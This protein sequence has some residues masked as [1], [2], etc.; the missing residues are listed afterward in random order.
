M[1]MLKTL[2]RLWQEEAVWIMACSVPVVW[3]LWVTWHNGWNVPFYDL[4]AVIPANKVFVTGHATF[5]DLIERVNEHVVLFP[6]VFFMPLQLLLFPGQFIPI[7]GQA[8]LL[9]RLFSF[10]WLL[11]NAFLLV[12]LIRITKPSKDRLTERLLMLCAFVLVF[13]IG[14]WE[15]WV[16]I[17]EAY[18]FHVTCILAAALVLLEQKRYR[19]PLTTAIVL[20][21]LATFSFGNGMVGWAA[22]LPLV[23]RECSAKRIRSLGMW[24]FTGALCTAMFLVQSISLRKGL[25]P[26]AVPVGDWVQ[27]FV[28]FLGTPLAA[29][30]AMARAAGWLLLLG[31][32]GSVMWAWWARTCKHALPW[33][34]ILLFVLISAALIATA[35][36]DHGVNGA[37]VPR[38]MTISYLGILSLLVMGVMALRRHVMLQRLLVLLVIG[39]NLFASR[40]AFDWL[41]HVRTLS[42][43]G[44]PCW[45]SYDIAS[46]ACLG[47]L[48]VPENAP[49]VRKMADTA[50][51]YGMLQ[52]FS[53]PP[54]ASVHED[55]SQFGE[56]Q[57]VTRVNDGTYKGY[58]FSGWAVMPG[59][60]QANHVI[61][62]VGPHRM[63]VAHTQAFLDTVELS[64]SHNAC[65]RHA[66]WSV[67]VDDAMMQRMMR[68]PPLQAWMY[69]EHNNMLFPVLNK[70]VGWP[71]RIAVPSV[72]VLPRTR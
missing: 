55:I 66:G 40:T 45:Q 17:L 53:V 23:Y 58:R 51:S 26:Y 61:L 21:V 46:D 15:I 63:L 60:R 18:A 14:Q 9:R 68:T 47:P 65:Y 2:R 19:F 49:L 30:I 22:L 56:I 32:M 5:W 31:S 36:T 67:V 42:M 16:S 7:S 57:S 72:P 24:L 10:P 11:C 3:A 6:H 71:P 52:T 25:S 28:I 43:Q 29:S 8:Y 50:R 70:I 1:R 64:I 34:C 59:C 38:Y 13:S 27:F 33:L 62:T 12:R 39:M 4:L 41:D 44:I 54:D 48:L 20:M 35:R 69:D 37:H